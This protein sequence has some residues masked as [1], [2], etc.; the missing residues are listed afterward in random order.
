MA[1]PAAPAPLVTTRTSSSFFPTTFRAL[2]RCCCRYHSR[3]VLIVMEDGNITALFQSA[4]DF[5]A[6]RSRNILQ[7][8]SAKASCQETYSFYNLIHIFASDTQR[9][10]IY[11]L[12]TALKSTHFPSITGI[13]ASGP[14]SPS[15]RTAVPSV[16]TA[17]RFPLLVYL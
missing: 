9:E 4:L 5:K 8:Y 10:S 3:T 14:I 13:P 17:T 2:I 12:Q 11:I 1:I 16:I 15:P 7:V 6:S